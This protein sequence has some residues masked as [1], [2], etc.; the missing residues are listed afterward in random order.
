MASPEKKRFVIVLRERGRCFLHCDREGVIDAYQSMEA[1][2]LDA[3]ASL[4]ADVLDPFIATVP[5]LDYIQESVDEPINVEYFIYDTAVVHG[6]P[7][8]SKGTKLK[9]GRPV[10]HG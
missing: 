1:A 6:I 2:E 10:F 8:N 4:P 7:V 3:V 5:D 9:G